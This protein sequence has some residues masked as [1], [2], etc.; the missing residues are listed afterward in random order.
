MLTNFKS[1]K[2]LNVGF[3]SGNGT[4]TTKQFY[5]F[6]DVPL[7]QG[8]YLYRIKQ[9]D[10][11][12]NYEYSNIIEVNFATHKSF[13]LYQNYPN[14]FNPST[15]I[16]YQVPTTSKVVLKIFDALGKEV[17]T[18]V[19]EEKQSGLHEVSFNASSYPSG[20]YL[21]RMFANDKTFTRKM[22]L[23]K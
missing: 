19:N 20:L 14:P 18:L 23:A 16:G 21:C 5:S 7:Q 6:M 8:I 1:K 11:N 15:T 10:F 9:I 3:V 22:M 13:I 17:N 2:W 12:G 4:T